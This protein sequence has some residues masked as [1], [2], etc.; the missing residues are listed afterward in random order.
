MKNEKL[1]ERISTAGPKKILAC[2]DGVT[3]FNNP[4]FLA[5]QMAT[6]SPYAQ[7]HVAVKDFAGFFSA[8]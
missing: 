2:D 7:K 1:I 4:A 3:T 6:A 5:F 8:R